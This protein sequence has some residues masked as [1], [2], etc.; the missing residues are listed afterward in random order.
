M[1]EHSRK[2]AIVKITEGKLAKT[3]KKMAVKF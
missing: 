1:A 2:F 3:N